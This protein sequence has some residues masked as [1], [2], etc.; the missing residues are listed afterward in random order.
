MRLTDWLA[1]EQI[2]KAEFARRI[3]RTEGMITQLLN[4]ETWV[5]RET[6]R[7]IKNVTNGA[8]TANDFVDGELR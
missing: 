3:R 1:R 4:G 7:R 5:S 2:S 6:A 8:V